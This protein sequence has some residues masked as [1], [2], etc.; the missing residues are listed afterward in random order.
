MFAGVMRSQL[1]IVYFT[2]FAVIVLKMFFYACS[3]I[4]DLST[5]RNWHTA[6]NNLLFSHVFAQ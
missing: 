6:L 3:F 1:N 2:V 5:C 4:T